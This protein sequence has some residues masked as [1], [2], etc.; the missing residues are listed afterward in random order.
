MKITE[1]DFERAVDLAS[2]ML[3]SGGIIVYP[4]DTV[5]GLGGDATSEDVVRKIYEIK[6][7]R[8][9][10]PLS[11]M[12]ADPGMMEYYC[13][14]GIWEDMILKKYLPG[15]Y[16]F[17]LKKR[18]YLA[19]TQTEKLGVRIPDSAFCQELCRRF[20]RPIITTSANLTGEPP[21]VDFNQVNEKILKKAN[22]AIDG[23]L[24]KFRQP[25]VVVDLV[26]RKMLREGAKEGISLL[27]LPEP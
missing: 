25:S 15:P 26:E 11:V 17:V 23:G 22:L 21:P 2:I 19:A 1:D 8:E 24:T 9:K 5:Y 10:R 27:E 20:G 16:T 13:D 3:K 7:I 12:M 14:T 4:T 6:G 18:K